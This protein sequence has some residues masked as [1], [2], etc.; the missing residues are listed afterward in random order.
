MRGAINELPRIPIP[1]TSVNKGKEKGRSGYA[2][3]RPFRVA[4]LAC[5]RSA[6]LV[7]GLDTLALGPEAEL[8]VAALLAR[9]LVLRRAGGRE[10]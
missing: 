10:L 7:D 8:L 1:R 5:P 9:W 6:R 2:P 4:V 3:A